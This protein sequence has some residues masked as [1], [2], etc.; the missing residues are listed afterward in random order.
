MVDDIWRDLSDEADPDALDKESFMAF[1][2]AIA[3]AVDDLDQAAPGQQLGGYL[4]ERATLR[5]EAALRV[6]P[7]LLLEQEEKARKTL[8]LLAQTVDGARG[9]RESRS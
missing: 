8:R 3:Q 4:L 1:L 2:F 6:E 5:L 9:I 7:P